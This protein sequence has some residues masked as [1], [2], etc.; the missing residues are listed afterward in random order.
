MPSQ[1]DVAFQ[2]SAAP[3]LSSWFGTSVTLKRDAIETSS[4]TVVWGAQESQSIDH[5]TGIAT[6]IRRRVYRV[7]K[8]DVVLAGDQLRPQAG[9]LILDGTDELLI[10][11]IDGKPAV[12]E[13]PGGYHWI[14][15]T[16]RHA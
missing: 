13:D 6:T 12:E 3:Q 5:E 4:F 8:T 16:N 9:D 1:F 14:C 2:L 7:L 11:A 15:R 10:A